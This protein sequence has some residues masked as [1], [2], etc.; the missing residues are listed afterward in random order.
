MGDSLYECLCWLQTRSRREKSELRAAAPFESLP[1]PQPQLLRQS[2]STTEAQH[3]IPLNRFSPIRCLLVSP[4]RSLPVAPPRLA[5]RMDSFSVA[6][7]GDASQCSAPL[8]SVHSVSL[9]RSSA[10]DGGSPSLLEVVDLAWMLLVGGVIF[11]PLLRWSRDK[12]AYGKLR[13]GKKD[14]ES[15]VDSSGSSQAQHHADGSVTDPSR[16]SHAAGGT[17][18]DEWKSPSLH[19]STRTA[20]VSYYLFASVLNGMMLAEVMVRASRIQG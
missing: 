15:E 9:A 4:V 13:H 17:A 3:N 20:F 6:D 16:P 12:G 19:V 18:S 8:P 5:S 7:A 14:D 1:Q 10:L 11:S 2:S